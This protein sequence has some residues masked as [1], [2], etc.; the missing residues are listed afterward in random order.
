MPVGEPSVAQTN[1]MMSLLPSACATSELFF[2]CV[3]ELCIRGVAF[4]V[5][6]QFLHKSSALICIES[7]QIS[8]T[9][10]LKWTM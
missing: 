6:V 10:S 8:T 1:V 7:L 2:W 4:V 3:A 5:A 9:I